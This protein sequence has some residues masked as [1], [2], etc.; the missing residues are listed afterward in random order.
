MVITDVLLLSSASTPHL[1]FPSSET[2]GSQIT[3][4]IE[5]NQAV[6]ISNIVEQGLF[7]EKLPSKLL[8]VC[9]VAKDGAMGKTRLSLSICSG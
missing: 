5:I 3:K 8:L 1:D 6:T 2:P 9:T 4:M 7:V